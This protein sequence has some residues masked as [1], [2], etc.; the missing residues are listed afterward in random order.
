MLMRIHA[1]PYLIKIKKNYAPDDL[2]ARIVR[3]RFCAF[4]LGD[5]TANTPEGDE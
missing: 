3:V 4:W 2:L 1:N 5:R